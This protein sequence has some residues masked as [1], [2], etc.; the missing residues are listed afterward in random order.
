MYVCMYIVEMSG[1]YE[2]VYSGAVL[3]V[4]N[5]L[6]ACSPICLHAIGVHGRVNTYIYICTYVHVGAFVREPLMCMSA[7]GVCMHV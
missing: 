2:C 5:R 7:F 3:E 1:L 6:E 4:R